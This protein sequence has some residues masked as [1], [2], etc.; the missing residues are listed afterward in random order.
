MLRRQINVGDYGGF[1]T[2]KSACRIEHRP[3]THRTEPPCKS[4]NNQQQ[5]PRLRQSS[6]GINKPP[7]STHS[8]AATCRP[9]DCSRSRM[10]RGT[11]PRCQGT[12]SFPWDQQLLSGLWQQP[13]IDDQSVAQIPV[14]T[15]RLVA[16]A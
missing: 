15:L 7:N 11:Q 9:A 14:Q 1:R 5:L 6:S 12:A 16:H 2:A 3:F 13:T 8:G 4:P 10:P